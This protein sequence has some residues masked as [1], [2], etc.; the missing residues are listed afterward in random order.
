MYAFR[1]PFAVGEYAGLSLWGMDYKI[2]LVIS[3]VIGYTVSK[4]IGI[5]VIAEME[6]HRRVFALVGLILAAE[7]ALV[8]FGLFSHPYNFVFM[9]LN[10]LPL[11]M[12]WGLVFGF[13]EG[14]QTT[15]VLAAALS[16]SFIVSSGVVK[17]V[18]KYAMAVWDVPE[19][20]MPA[21]TGLLFLGPLLVCAWMLSCVP[22]PTPSDEQSR[23]IRVPM[24]RRDRQE[25]LRA[26]FSAICLLV[27]AHMLLTAARD[28]RDK[29]AVE[30][31]GAV[32]A[33]EAKHLAISEIPVAFAVLLP[34]A[35]IML[36]RSHR[37]AV[38]VLHG[39]LAFGFALAG[40]S[41][42]LFRQDQLT[43]FLWFISVGTGLYLAYVPFH[44]IL[45]ERIVALM[46]RP[47]NAGYLIYVADATGYLSSVA[48]LLWKNF[49]ASVVRP[50]DF[51]VN[52]T[53]V[54]TVVGCLC[55]GLSL[56]LFVR[57][58][59]AANIAGRPAGQ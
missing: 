31:L 55:V 9:F 14:R 28:Y 6:R 45:F 36:I 22:H 25:L 13:L 59:P 47:A 32:G 8:G 56:V 43:G 16:A 38:I 34:L 15:E 23:T 53:Y 21:V 30:I 2:V 7:A 20:W 52:T 58:G 42:Y 5:R 10:G 41:T 24:Q 4:F 57:Q 54:I 44:S 17:A 18:G 51:F 27:I 1:K 12:V 37:S 39:C 26:S 3:Q 46:Q 50:L 48:I 11:G 40:V 19:F 49:A 29:F 33:G 35:A